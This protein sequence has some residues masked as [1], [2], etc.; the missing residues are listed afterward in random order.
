MYEQV[1]RGGREGGREG[2]KVELVGWEDSE[3]KPGMQRDRKGEICNI[4]KSG[5]QSIVA[6]HLFAID[7][8]LSPDH[9]DYSMHNKTCPSRRFFMVVSCTSAARSHRPTARVLVNC[10]CTNCC[11]CDVCMRENGWDGMGWDGVGVRGNRR[12]G[13]R[14]EG[15]REGGRKDIWT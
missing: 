1:E 11:T 12:E 9:N 8:I 10:L 2:G 14:R 4:Q 3:G 15:E 5:K 6:I 7:I 13:E